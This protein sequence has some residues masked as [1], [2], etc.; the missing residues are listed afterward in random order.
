MGNN[1]LD[2]GLDE[3]KR[4]KQVDRSILIY[5]NLTHIRKSFK[6]YR[7]YKKIV[8]WWLLILSTFVGLKR[9]IGL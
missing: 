5:Q 2:I 7:F 8:L 4:M 6:E 9:F 3:F 1:G